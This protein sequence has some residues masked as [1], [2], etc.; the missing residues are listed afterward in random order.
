M[1]DDPMPAPTRL[2][3]YAAVTFDLD[4][5][6]V[7][8]AGEIVEAVNATLVEAGV[9][10]RPAPEIVNLIGNGL[11]ALMMNLLAR[12]MLEQPQ[13][14]DRL[15]VEVLLHRVEVIYGAL[16]GRSAQAYPGALQ[17]LVDLREA[18]IRTGCVTN[19]DGSFTQRLLQ[20]TG[21][22]PHLDLVLAGDTLPHKKPHA[23]VLRTAAERLGVGTDRLAH[24][25]DSRTDID[26][27]RNAGVAAWAVPYGYNGG[28]PVAL[29]MPTRLFANLSEVA[30]HVLAE[31]LPIAA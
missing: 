26:A 3:R 12:L 29:A 10:P 14:A 4:G 9:T 23:S 19:K 18:G 20:A 6:L 25:G 27:A 17:A 24:V 5:T 31:R 11:R 2:R 28:E 22:A 8:T 30:L 16:A 15:S 7:D 13:L 21:L 1:T